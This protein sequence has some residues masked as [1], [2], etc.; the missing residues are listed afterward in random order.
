MSALLVLAV[1]TAAPVPAEVGSAY[2]AQGRRDPFLRSAVAGTPPSCPGSGPVTVRAA[3]VALAGV[4]VGPGGPVALLVDAAGRS[5]LVR[6]GEALCDG[7]VESVTA[8][9]VTLLEG[10]RGDGT[11]GRRLVHRLDR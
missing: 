3:A 1:M 10:R 7:H 11:P 5:F 2:A 8:H 4:L 6:P 9:A